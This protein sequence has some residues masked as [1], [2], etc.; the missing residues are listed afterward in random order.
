MYAVLSFTLVTLFFTACKK[1][2]TF[3]R[4]KFIGTYQATEDCT[5]GQS[6]TM[7]I[8]ATAG[9][10]NGVV[11]SNFGNFDN[12]VTATVSGNNIT[13]PSQTF[14][15]NAGGAL[16]IITVSG[17]GSISDKTMTITYTWMDAAMGG[18]DTCVMTGTKQ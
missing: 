14:N 12:A 15:V 18:S 10:D 2:E 6:F 8:Q 17:N 7:T 16:L 4:D 11:I 5:P 13:V 9:G 1:D 3:D